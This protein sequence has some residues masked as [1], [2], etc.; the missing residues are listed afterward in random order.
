MSHRAPLF[1]VEV[2]RGLFATAE[3][4]TF[5]VDSYDRATLVRVACWLAAIEGHVELAPLVAR[6]LL[7][8]LESNTFADHC[9]PCA[10]IKSL[11]RAH[12]IP[13]SLMTH[14]SAQVRYAV[15]DTFYRTHSP[16]SDDLDLAVRHRAHMGLESYRPWWHPFLQEAPLAS[17]ATRAMDAAIEGYLGRHQGLDEVGKALAGLPADVAQAVAPSLLSALLE[18]PETLY[19]AA[20][21]ALVLGPTPLDRMTPTITAVLHRLAYRTQLAPIHHTLLDEALRELA[22]DERTRTDLLTLAASLRRPDNHD[23]AASWQIE[24]APTCLVAAPDDAPVAAQGDTAGLTLELWKALVRALA[25]P[26]AWARDRLAQHPRVAGELGRG[27]AV[28]LKVASAQLEASDREPVLTHLGAIA[29]MGQE[30]MR[31]TARDAIALALAGLVARLAPED[32]FVRQLGDSP[33]HILRVVYLRGVREP[34]RYAARMLD[35]PRPDVRFEARIRLSDI[36]PWAGLMLGDPFE[37]LDPVAAEAL[38]PHI[39]ALADIPRVR[40]ED[41][42]LAHIQRLAHLFS[43]LPPARSIAAALSL[44]EQEGARADLGAMVRVVLA[45]DGGFDAWRLWLGERRKKRGDATW[46]IQHYPHWAVD[47]ARGQHPEWPIP[48]PTDLQ[49]R[50]ALG[51]FALSRSAETPAAYRPAWLGASM[52][53]W[54]D[55][56][57]PVPLVEI[58]LGADAPSEI[59]SRIERMH[60]QPHW[61]STCLLVAAAHRGFPGW[62]WYTTGAQALAIL[63]EVERH[64]LMLTYVAQPSSRLGPWA[65]DELAR[66]ATEAE[67]SSSDALRQSLSN[68][69]IGALRFATSHMSAALWKLRRARLRAGLADFG[70]ALETMTFI[71]HSFGSP[72]HTHNAGWTPPELAAYRALWLAEANAAMAAGPGHRALFVSLGPPGLWEAIDAD[73]LASVAC[74]ATPAEA[75]AIALRRASFP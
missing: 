60:F 71:A 75:A 40:A 67:S 7:S 25:E 39:V 45:T 16:L 18:L 48:F 32:P 33:N 43:L 52:S 70:E 49:M 56:A 36:P 54:H 62:P 30:S 6:L 66:R 59:R 27:L 21:R 28:L 46:E 4:P 34:T 44:L 8:E 69:R 19:R 41:L 53:L 22:G 55:A 42:A 20:W 31:P 1:A 29:A 13:E 64:E 37:D 50:A 11:C 15:A 57:D 26:D 38:V 35:D 73:V 61:E 72:G 14:P 9:A 65:A 51:A 2:V 68:P 63:P 12:P 23:E 47:P 17:A 58:Y 24:D 74:D 3:S 10:I 5:R